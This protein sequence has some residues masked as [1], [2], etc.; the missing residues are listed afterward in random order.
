MDIKSYITF[1]SLD[2]VHGR[3]EPDSGVV[4]YTEKGEKYRRDICGLLPD[5]SVLVKDYGKYNLRE[6]LARKLRPR[7]FRYDIIYGNTIELFTAWNCGDCQIQSVMPVNDGEHFLLSLSYTDGKNT[8][9]SINSVGDKRN[10]I[11]ESDAYPYGFSLN[12]EKTKLAFHIAGADGAYN[13]CGVYAINVMNTDGSRRTLVRAERDHLYF[14]PV[15]SYD[16]QWLAYPDC[17]VRARLIITNIYPY[18]RRLTPR[19]LFRP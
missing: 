3:I 18:D 19:L 11:F 4:S 15:W 7:F 14:A 12:R 13:P 10:T 8:V 5:G 1:L 16:G 2:G 9:I 6:D 17:N